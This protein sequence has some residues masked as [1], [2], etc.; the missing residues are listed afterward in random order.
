MLLLEARG[1]PTVSDAQLDRNNDG[2][3]QPVEVMLSINVGEL[4]CAYSQ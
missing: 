2:T 4:L 1:G 3:R